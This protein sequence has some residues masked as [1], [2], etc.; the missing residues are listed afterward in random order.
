MILTEES[1]KVAST[2][3]ETDLNHWYCADCY[4]NGEIAFCST[5]ISNSTE[6]D[7]DETNCL[8]CIELDYCPI[9][10]T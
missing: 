1:T 10:D 9:C 8:V 3:F 4:P 6:T 5:D 2:D 7:D